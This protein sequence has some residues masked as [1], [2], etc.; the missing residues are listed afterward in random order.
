M[1]TSFAPVK[2]LATQR[3]SQIDE[4]VFFNSKTFKLSPTFGGNK[5]L[6]RILHKPFMFFKR[7]SNLYADKASKMVITTA[8]KCNRFQRILL[9]W[10]NP[11]VP[12]GCDRF[13]HVSDLGSCKRVIAMPTLH[14]HFQ[15]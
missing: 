15:N 9:F 4:H 6:S 2:A 10:S 3:P 12:Q 13:N 1:W 5:I 11:M 8:A 14:V 7:L